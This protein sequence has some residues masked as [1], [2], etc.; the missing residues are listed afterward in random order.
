MCFID[1]PIIPSLIMKMKP[2][3]RT[4]HFPSMYAIA[5][6][7]LLARNL[8]AMQKF[9]PEEFQFFPQTWL[10]PGDLKAFKD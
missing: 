5:R 6:K 1:A 9:E 7:N 2:Y 3:Q 10:I 8:L 4:N